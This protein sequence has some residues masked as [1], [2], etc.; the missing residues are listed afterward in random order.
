MMEKIN[1]VILPLCSLIFEGV[2]V[3]VTGQILIGRFSC[4][5]D[6][7]T[8]ATSYIKERGEI[9]D[10]SCASANPCLQYSHSSQSVLVR[11]Y[12]SEEF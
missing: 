12:L 1:M 7:D 2:H 5:N 3:H 9:C 6:F 4:P 11:T 10:T 8:K